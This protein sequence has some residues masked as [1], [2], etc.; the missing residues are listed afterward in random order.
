MLRASPP[1]ESGVNLRFAEDA[2]Y[3]SYAPTGLGRGDVGGADAVSQVVVCDKRGNITAAGGNSAARLFVAT[4]L[5]RATVLRDT[6]MI[7][8]AL[9]AMG[10]TCP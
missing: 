3:F 10:E 9:T 8:D 7:D 5:G 4:P 6:G 1:V 2:R